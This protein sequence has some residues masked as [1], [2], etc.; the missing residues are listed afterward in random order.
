MV[1]VFLVIGQLVFAQR[2]VMHDGV[3]SY[4]HVV[5]KGNTLY[6]LSKEY[7]ATIPRILDANPEAR[8]G[9]KIGQKIYIPLSIINRREARNSPE[10]EGNVIRHTVAKRETLYSLSKKYKIEI[11]DILTANPGL[12][13]TGLKK[14]SVINIPIAEVNVDKDFIR[15]AVED[16][17]LQ[18]EVLLGETLFNLSKTYDVRIEDIKKVNGGLIEG[19]RAGMT[20]RIPKLRQGFAHSTMA[21]EPVDSESEPIPAGSM[22]KMKVGLLLP[23]SL[24]PLDSGTAIPRSPED[25]MRL[26][27]IAFEFYRG[28]QIAMDEMAERGM[29]ID[30]TVYDVTSADKDV[31]ACLRK[32]DLKE[33]DL[34]VGPLHR[35]A[36]KKISK[37]GTF[38][39]VHRISPLSSSLDVDSGGDDN[40]SKLKP[41]DGHQI[42]AMVQYIK[43]RF[44]SENII[45]L[46]SEVKS[47]HQKVSSLWNSAESDSSS[48]HIPL[49]KIAWDSK[50]VGSLISALSSTSK[51]IIIFPVEHRPAIT[52]LLSSL[53]TTDFRDKEIVL[54][55]MEDWLGFDNL[56][57]DLLERLQLHVSSS[58]FI[59]WTDRKTVDFIKTFKDRYNTIPSSSA[60]ALLAYDMT[61]YYLEGMGRYGEGFLSNMDKYRKHGLSTG[62]EM[63]KTESGGWS[64]HYSVI[65]KY[66]DQDLVKVKVQ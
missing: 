27:D 6:G 40:V 24:T 42:E 48:A 9:I 30:V 5:E 26:T 19:L 1:I 20:L 36:F 60:Y 52:E 57:A 25:I 47:W 63:V 31:E 17:L 14:G 7:S 39:K 51:N 13:G 46:T 64:N 53:A 54:F 16:S 61:M 37:K 3:M 10:V 59:D 56:D 38:S 18:H 34:I 12:E 55:G 41:S 32:T 28:V 45:L 23:F 43:N 44:S 65:L 15:P 50:E 4:V 29:D 62:F 22:K 58:S 21:S 2:K 35:E 66:E 33:M 8:L 11:N 49:T